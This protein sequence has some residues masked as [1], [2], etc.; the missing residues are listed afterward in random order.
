MRANGFVAVLRRD[1]QLG[2]RRRG[3]L[4]NP[5]L[6]FV[7]VV[8]LFPLG[9]G[10]TPDV[11]TEIA[12]GVLWVA[13]LLATLLSFERLFR[14]DFDD[15]SLEQLLM[16][17]A[18]LPALMLAKSL[19]HWLLTGLPL[20]VIAPVLAT[21]LFLPIHAWPVMTATLLLGTPTLSLVGGI[22]VALTV[23]LRRGGVL[24]AVLILPLYIPVLIFATG[25]LS[26]AVTG[27]DVRGPL[28]L[29]AAMLLMA[30]MLC[31]FATAFAC[32]I[33]VD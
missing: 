3:E 4:L 12:P 26:G 10:P 6:F 15:G 19:A 9:L 30:L 14:A 1:L 8:T 11:L 17:P 21:L 33:S 29:L 18:P 13:A 23:G 5:P 7:V 2:L 28:A 31:P 32:R 24:L 20:V 16:S 27:L 22:A 25:A